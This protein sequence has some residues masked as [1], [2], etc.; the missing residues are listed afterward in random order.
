MSVSRD[1]KLMNA[2][3][4]ETGIRTESDNYDR[5]QHIIV[6]LADTMAGDAYEAVTVNPL[7]GPRHSI[8]KQQRKTRRKRAAAIRREMKPKLQAVGLLPAGS[9]LWLLLTSPTV[10]SFLFN[11]IVEVLENREEG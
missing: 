9:I 6:H 10:W 2:A 1:M 5:C 3:M 4:V 11:W 8:P 7:C